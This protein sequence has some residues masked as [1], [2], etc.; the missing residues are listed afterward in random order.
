MTPLA[1]RQLAAA[2][3]LAALRAK[4]DEEEQDEDTLAVIE[5]HRK[6]IVAELGAIKPLLDLESTEREEEL[7][8]RVEALRSGRTVAISGRGQ[9]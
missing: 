8:D 2:D 9:K 5:Q 7:A 1:K 3:A 4:L 6:L